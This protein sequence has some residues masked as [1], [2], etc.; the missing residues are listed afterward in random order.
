MNTEFGEKLQNAIDNRNK[1]QEYS[2]KSKEG[3][4]ILLMDASKEQLTK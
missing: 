3:N 4:T 1:I 2:W